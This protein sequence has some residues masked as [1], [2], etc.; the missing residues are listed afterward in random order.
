MDKQPPFVINY[1]KDIPTNW[2]VSKFISGYP[3]KEV[4]MARKKG[5]TWFVVGINGENRPKEFV[6]DISFI[7]KKEGYLISENE[8]GF[9]Q[10]TI[11]PAAK[12]TI[13]MKAYGGF[14][15]KF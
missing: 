10:K 15:M 4:I 14:V 5:D 11:T 3:G 2:D 12:L 8:N 13:K 7:N 6:I 1:L 9:T